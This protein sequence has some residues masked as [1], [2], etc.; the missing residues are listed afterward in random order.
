MKLREGEFKQALAELARDVRPASNPLRNARRLMFDSPWQEEVYLKWTG[1]QLLLDSEAESVQ[2]MAGVYLEL[3]QAYGRW[4][5]HKGRPRD[6]LSLL[7]DGPLLNEDG[8]YALAMEFALGAVWNETMD[9]FKD[10]ANPEAVR[11]TIVSAMAMYM[12]LWLL[13][14]PASKGLAAILTASLIAYLGV[15]TV[16][17]LMQG[18]MQLVEDVKGVTSFAQLREVGERFG[19]VMSKNV[20]RIF[21]MLVTAAIGNTAGL[22]MTGPGLPG[23]SRA[24][25][26]AETQGGFQLAAVAEVE[27]VAVSAE[28]FTI[29]LAPGAVAMSS[30]GPGGSV[31][32]PAADNAPPKRL[33]KNQ[34]PDDLSWELDLAR[35]LGVRPVGVDSPEFLDYANQGTIKWVVTQEGELKIIPHTWRALEISHAVASGGQPVLAAGEAQIAIHG[36]TRFGIAITPN[37]GHFLKGASR[38]VSA[39]AL[40]IGRQAFAKF[41]ITFPP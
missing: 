32:S 13:P 8:R 41:G 29:A 18:W 14:E 27:S 15:D 1:R 6:C 2:R 37:S 9:A 25:V 34:L 16:W 38:A 17:S 36:S 31:S 11:A 26:L 24:A 35:R 23:Y 12:T 40:E 28:G 20:A 22:A 21:I 4:C 39:N 19:R 5:E 33:L 7:K 30:R 10:M 3:T